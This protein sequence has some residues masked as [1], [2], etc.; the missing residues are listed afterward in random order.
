MD[1]LSR[2][3][4][5]LWLLLILVAAAF[6]RLWRIDILPPGFHLDESFEGLEAWRILTD[7]A[8]RPIFLEG[9]FGVAPF[10]AW[11]NALTFGVGG[12]FGVPPGPTLMRITAALFG[13]ACVAAV[14]WLA[15]ELRLIGRPTARS[16]TTAAFP[17]FAAASLA[18]MRWH[19]HFSRMGIEPILMPLEWAL[20]CALLLHG[21][22]TGRWA[23]FAGLGLV[24]AAM[25]Y[26]YQGAWH[27]PF[28]TGATAL[29]LLFTQ[30][31]AG[32]P[33]DRRQW[34]GLVLAGTLALLLVAP[35]LLHLARNPE[36]ALLRPVQISVVGETTSPAD[37]GVLENTWRT[38]YMFWPFGATG[39]LDP[40]RN[41]P[42]TP[43]LPLALAIPF[44]LGIAIS[45]RHITK[46]IGWIPLSAGIALL[47]VGFISEYAPHFHR[48][49]G[50][51]APAALLCGLGLDA[52]A[53]GVAALL[54]RVKV[55]PQYR[56][57]LAWM[58]PGLFLLTATFVGARDYFVRWAAL[59]DLYHAFDEGLW[60]VGRWVAAQPTEQIIFLSPRSTDHPTL[61]FAWKTKPGGHP[62]PV[63]F[64]G[65]SIFPVSNTPPAVSETYISIVHEDFRT[66]LLMQDVL[67]DAEVIA[68]WNDDN[69][70]PY[71]TAWQRAAGSSAQR[72]PR[73]GR[74]TAAG[75]GIT[76][77]G[78]D[79]LPETIYPGDMLYLQLHWRV[80]APPT[81]EWTVFTH[82]IDPKHPEQGPVAGTDSQPGGGSLP[83]SRWQSGWRILDEYQIPIPADLL[84][85]EYGLAVGL[86]TQDGRRLPQDEPIHLGAITIKAR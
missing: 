72:P 52:L 2:R 67:P 66:P 42:G 68:S 1:R 36:L 16:I 43:A 12:W 19:I 15:Q 86:Y 26:S 10:N 79:V 46:P 5:L 22:R 23:A 6:L 54:G 73:I 32:E 74:E 34:T 35:L 64:D 49:L 76:L 24:L 58:L 8:Y 9:N 30:R 82:V 56:A 70:A 51:S 28:V 21:L 59:P 25:L 39:D 71:A 45:L 13:I 29:I 18:I 80:D 78:Y 61:T 57:A 83:T 40:R 77:L 81:A 4:N 69:G 55:S 20:A 33:T 31:R 50:A 60:Q 44:F 53:R 38:L 63:T 84:P 37:S 85:G 14:W 75:D 41:L 62:P 65:R 3:T 17:L 27:F 47:I 48:I 7:P 11:A